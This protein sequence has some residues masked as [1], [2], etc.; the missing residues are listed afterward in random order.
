MY[1]KAMSDW[2]SG[3]SAKKARTCSSCRSAHLNHVRHLLAKEVIAV[4][5]VPV[6]DVDHQTGQGAVAREHVRQPTEDPDG[7]AQPGAREEEAQVV[8]YV[9]AHLPAQCA[10]KN[11]TDDGTRL[12][13]Q[14]ETAVQL[15]WCGGGHGGRLRRVKSSLAGGGCSG[16]GA[17]TWK[18]ASQK[19]DS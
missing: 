7:A 17:G 12:C 1:E 4:W 8:G 6:A 11:G 19:R 14:R 15:G 10:H 5:I 2:R 9:V 18:E 3:V 13:L 16:T